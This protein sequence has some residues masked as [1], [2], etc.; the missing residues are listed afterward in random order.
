MVV[1]AAISSGGATKR[2]EQVLSGGEGGRREGG[3]LKIKV[4][5]MN[6]RKDGRTEDDTG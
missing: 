6:E 3:E 2:C 5:G 4:G 1:V